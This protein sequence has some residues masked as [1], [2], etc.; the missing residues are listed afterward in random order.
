MV[1]NVK[2]TWYSV[3]TVQWLIIIRVRPEPTTGDMKKYCIR[4]QNS[5]WNKIITHKWHIIFFTLFIL[6]MGKLLLLSSFFAILCMHKIH[7]FSVMICI[8]IHIEWVDIAMCKNH[9][10]QRMFVCLLIVTALSNWALCMWN[11][12]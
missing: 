5:K 3:H 8:F 7:I 10:I 11:E 1:Q 9:I 2:C 6:I 4:Q 12:N